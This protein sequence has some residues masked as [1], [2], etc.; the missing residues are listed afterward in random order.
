ML[1]ELFTSKTRIRVLLKLFLNPGVSSYLRELAQEFSVSPAAIKD[2]LDKLSQAG[3]LS[4]EKS[5]RSILFRADTTH[6]FFPEIH[7]IVRKYLGIDRI[8]E[9]V[10]ANL[11]VVQRVYILD[12]YAQGK[13]SGLIDV[14]IVGDVNR[15]KLEAMRLS[16]EKKIN[17]LLRVMAVSDE[18]FAGGREVF[19]AR[20][21]WR[22][23]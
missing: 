12:D 21:H 11:G 14:L 20:P 22:V 2:E 6:P 23:V 7:S 15:D 10:M 13:D 16:T 18:E 17:R 1:T 4:K 5:G 8:I 19:L 3:Y 9:Q